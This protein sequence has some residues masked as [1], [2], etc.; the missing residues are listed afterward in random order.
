MNQLQAVTLPMRTLASLPIALVATLSLLYLMTQLI[1]TNVVA[2]D[3]KPRIKISPFIMEERPEIEVRQRELERPATP[4]KQPQVDVF[5]TSDADFLDNVVSVGI[6]TPTGVT[7]SDRPTFVGNSQLVAEIRVQPQYPRIAI[8]RNVEG[9]VDVEFD[10]NA[11]GSTQ[12][13]RVIEANP[14]GVFENVSLRAVAKWRYRAP[15]QDGK[16]VPVR[17]HRERLRFEID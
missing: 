3:T 1:A 2:I 16:A 7:V 6:P 12:N 15:M 10:I 5:N 4:E 8:T 17:G 14:E 11:D 13:I 9:Y